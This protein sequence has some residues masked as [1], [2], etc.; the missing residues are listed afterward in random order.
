M[1]PRQTALTPWLKPG[2]LIGALVPLGA[3]RDRCRCAA[4]SAPTLSPSR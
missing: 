2:V 4:G 3:A 1:A